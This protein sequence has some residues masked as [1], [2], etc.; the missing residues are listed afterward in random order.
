MAS[1]LRSLRNPN[2]KAIELGSGCGIVGLH[3]A[4]ACSEAQILLT[5]LPDAVDVLDGNIS[6]LEESA[7]T[8]VQSAI[9]DWDQDLPRAVA[10]ENFG[11]ILISDCTYNCDSIPALVKTL[12]ALVARSQ[13]A[14]IAVSMKVRHESEAVFHELMLRGAFEQLE[15]FNTL[16]LPDR[17]R[18]LNGQ[19]L[20]SVDVYVYRKVHE[21]T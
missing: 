8:R 10:T 18:S 15:H 17:Q 12:T 9:L 14:I 21:T 3:F 5:D 4:V 16:I 6:L 1:G 13:N 20:D 7:A 2:V 11:L 19:E